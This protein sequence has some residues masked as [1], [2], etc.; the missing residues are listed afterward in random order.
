MAGGLG[1]R[2]INAYFLEAP[3]FPSM[4]LW[5]D[6]LPRYCAHLEEARGQARAARDVCRFICWE[7]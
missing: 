2:A 7:T 1:L 5:F 4:V 6:L 3:N